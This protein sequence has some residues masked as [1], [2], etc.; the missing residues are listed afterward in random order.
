MIPF[1]GNVLVDSSLADAAAK[2]QPIPFDA[3]I[4]LWN[5]CGSFANSWFEYVKETLESTQR[6]WSPKFP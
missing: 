6:S 4:F 1:T 5:D 2:T 3:Y